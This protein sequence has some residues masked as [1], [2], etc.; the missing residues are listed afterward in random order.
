LSEGAPAQAKIARFLAL[1]AKMPQSE[2]P[3]WSLAQAYEEAGQTL[4]AFREYGELVTLKPDYCLAWL[5]L[6]A[7]ALRE[8][9]DPKVAREALENGRRLAIQQGH[10]APRSEADAL[11]REL[12]ESEGHEGREDDDEEWPGS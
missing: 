2:L 9:A 4:D 6:G 1:K 5:R 3:R 12:A 11:L 10:A 8:L 7:I